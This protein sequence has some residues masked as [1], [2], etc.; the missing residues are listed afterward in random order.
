MK[1]KFFLKN[2]PPISARQAVANAITNIGET[3]TV[4]EITP[5]GPAATGPEKK[6]SFTAAPLSGEAHA[7][8]VWLPM[9]R[10]NAR[11]CWSVRLIGILEDFRTLVDASS[12]EVLVRQNQTCNYTDAS[13]RVYTSDS[14]SP[15]SPGWQTPSSG[16]PAVVDR[17]LITL[18]ALSAVASP[19]GWINDGDNQTI[20][21]NVDASLNRNPQIPNPTPRPQG[22][23][24]RVFDFTL[25]LT[26]EPNNYENAAVANLFYRCNWMHDRLYEL[27]FTEA[28]GNFQQLISGGGELEPGSD[29]RVRPVRSRRPLS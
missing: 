17:Q 20:G 2:V 5:T 23:P 16:Q 9:S 28:A 22:S 7:S 11:L 1:M 24:S 3:I 26:Q 14:P 12:G 27:G 13:Y 18:P 15:F 21:N 19:N 8:L 25:D 29:S 6:Q 4:D 10:T